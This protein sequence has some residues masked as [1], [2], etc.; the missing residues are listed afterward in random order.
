MGGEGSDRDIEKCW[1][2][3]G[4]GRCWGL[5]EVGGIPMSGSNLASLGITNMYH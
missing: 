1:G 5:R 4:G 2:P 3:G